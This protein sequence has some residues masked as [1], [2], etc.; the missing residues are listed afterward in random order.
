MAPSSVRL[1]YDPVAVAHTLLVI[2]YHVLTEDVPYRDLGATSLDQRD[3]AAVERRLIRR[4]EA[5]GHTVTL[6]PLAA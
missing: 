1:T 6:S 4:L 3:R 2:I 5:L